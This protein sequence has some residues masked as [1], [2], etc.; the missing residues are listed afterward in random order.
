MWLHSKHKYRHFVIVWRN[1]RTGIYRA[2]LCS[3]FTPCG[4]FF[5]WNINACGFKSII[6]ASRTR[7]LFIT[8]WCV[9][10]AMGMK[11]PKLLLLAYQNVIFYNWRKPSSPVSS[12]VFVPWRLGRSQH[13][14]RPSSD[15]HRLIQQVAQLQQL[16]Q[17]LLPLQLDA[18]LSWD[19]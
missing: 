6:N 5:A 15:Q 19:P 12:L 2:R 3:S 1:R 18:A 10:W 7:P 11:A 17:Q 13:R 16:P 9:W 4:S 14:W 8:T